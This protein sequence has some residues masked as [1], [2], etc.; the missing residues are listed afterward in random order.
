MARP[1]K[2]RKKKR[3]ELGWLLGN[4]EELSEWRVHDWMA[5]Y[6]YHIG[7]RKYRRR[8]RLKNL[9]TTWVQQPYMQL[10][11]SGKRPGLEDLKLDVF[12]RRWS[13]VSHRRKGP[14]VLWPCL[15]VFIVIMSP[16]SFFFKIIFKMYLFL[17]VL[18]LHCYEGFSLVLVRGTLYLGCRC[19]S[20][21]WLL[22]LQSK[23]SRVQ[24]LQ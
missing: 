14:V 13:W 11:E 7:I 22:L 5:G 20:L 12:S 3:E 23:G 1:I 18:R 2:K 19:F 21:W 4:L 10:E 16:S 9:W 24:G 6:M 17:A 15:V 8:T